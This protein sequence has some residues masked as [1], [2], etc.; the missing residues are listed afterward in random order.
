MFGHKLRRHFYQILHLV[1]SARTIGAVWSQRNARANSGMLASGAIHA[2]RP[3]QLDYEPMKRT[4]IAVICFLIA[5]SA[6]A[7]VD[8]R[9]VDRLVADTMM[10]WSVPGMAVAI[11]KDD[12]VVY[13]K[14][15]GV[16][17]LGGEPAT[18][19]T[20]FG[21]ASTTKAFTTT[22][23]AMLVD[24]KKIKWDDPVRKH[25]EYFRLSD[26]CAD[27]MVTLRDIVSHRTGVSRHDELWDYT[28]LSR[29]EVIR[30]I[31]SVPLSKSFRSAYQYQNIMLMAAGEAVASA[32]GMSWEDLIRSRIFQ[33]LAMKSTTTSHEEWLARN[34][35]SGYAWSSKSRS[36]S[37]QKTDPYV[38]LGPAGTI[39]SSANDMAQWVRFHLAGGVIDGKRLVSEE[40][41]TETK[42]PQTVD[43]LEGASKEDNPET[44]L[45]TYGMAWRI[46]DYRGELLVSH[47]GALN[48]F[49][50]QVDL[51]PKQNAG[52]V[53]MSN[54]GRGAA[55]VAMRNALA[56]LLIGK[57]MK[58]WNVYYL[59][60]DAKGLEKAETRKKEREAKRHA[61]TRPSRELTAYAGTYTNAAF[62][63]AVVSVEN[64]ALVFTWSGLRL[65]MAHYHFDTFTAIDEDEDIEEQVTFTLDAN[66]EVKGFSMFGERFER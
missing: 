31:G 22:A 8:T 54:L 55:V 39:R 34:H 42:T 44:N 62:G 51:L 29:P 15:F 30:R 43:R 56:D 23:M 45:Y 47:G 6:L 16:R 49:R 48:G 35:A 64:D 25:V 63:S 60:L 26:P 11:V 10:A 20:L 3:L 32:S 37:P 33:P 36:V 61:N 38:S 7:Q 40:A 27:S 52:F 57:P 24:E 19:D 21:I 1:A 50:T 12:K 14:G 53:V 65:P 58:D 46:Q 4:F 9:V 17:E 5:T 2:E 18:A 66:G 13:A 28:S 59:E 41:L